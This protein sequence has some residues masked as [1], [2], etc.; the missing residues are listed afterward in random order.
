MISFEIFFYFNFIIYIERDE[1]L[2]KIDSYFTSLNV[3][4]LN[5]DE[6]LAID[7]FLNSE[8]FQNYYNNLYDDYKKDI[9]HQKYIIHKL[10]IKSCLIGS[11]FYLSFLFLYFYGLC[12][13]N[14]IKWNWLI[15]ENL[16]MFLCLGIFEYL[17][18]MEI[19]MHYDPLTDSEIKYYVINDI[20]NK[21]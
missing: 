3:S 19:I 1:I 2:K 8:Q 9:D 17:F 7:T 4:S 15:F 20:Y 21:L 14:K 13:K 16:F 12:K 18:F 5:N 10:I 6:K 11:I